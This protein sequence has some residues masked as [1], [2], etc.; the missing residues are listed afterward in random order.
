VLENHV[1]EWEERTVRDRDAGLEIKE[2]RFL[3]QKQNCAITEFP[4]TGKTRPEAREANREQTDATGANCLTP[5]CN[6]KM[7]GKMHF[8]V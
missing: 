3:H 5:A 2:V 7:K 4:E 1:K 8:W 6:A